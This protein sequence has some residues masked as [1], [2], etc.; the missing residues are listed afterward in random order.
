[1]FFLTMKISEPDP[2][3]IIADPPHCFVGSAYTLYSTCVRTLTSYKFSPAFSGLHLDL[4]LNINETLIY[5]A[6]I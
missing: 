5:W 6:T 2:H 4:L 1:M 3:Q